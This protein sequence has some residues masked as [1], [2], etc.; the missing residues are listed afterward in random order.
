LRARVSPPAD[1]GTPRNARPALLE[2]QAFNAAQIEATSA[3]RKAAGLGVSKWSC[4]RRCA[5]CSTA[6][7]LGEQGVRTVWI[8][9]IVRRLE[10]FR[11][12]FNEQQGHAPMKLSAR[13]VLLAAV[14]ALPSK[15]VFAF[16]AE[17]V[18]AG[19]MSYTQSCAACHGPELR[20]LPNAPLQGN[21]FIA[22]W[23]TRSTND[24]LAQDAHDDAARKP[25]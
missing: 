14:A 8:G 25:R 17:Q 21:E 22:K 9:A 10:S 3:A 15:F 18:E 13:L 16:T 11:K 2:L 7:R 24:L 4:I 5:R 6:P 23:R 12:H 1:I 20:N 19:L